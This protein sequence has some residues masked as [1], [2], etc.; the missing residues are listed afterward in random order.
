MSSLPTP[1]S[2]VYTAD[3]K[4]QRILYISPDINRITGCQSGEYFSG[5]LALLY[6]Q[7]DQCHRQQLLRWLKQVIAGRAPQRPF[8]GQTN[9]TDRTGAKD[10]AVAH[11]VMTCGFNNQQIVGHIRLIAKRL[12]PSSTISRGGCLI[13]R[14]RAWRAGAPLPEAEVIS[15]PAPAHLSAR[16]QEVLFL[17]ADGLTTREIA[18]QLFISESTV[19]SHRKNLLRKYLAKNTAELVKLAGREYLFG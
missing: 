8:R 10:L 2:A 19:I 9:L 12:Q 4:Q 5:D 3:L 11:D 18:E 16:E 15:L 13:N 7:F 17:I 14:I 1:I 6:H